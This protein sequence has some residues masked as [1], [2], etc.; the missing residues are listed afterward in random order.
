MQPGQTSRK[1]TLLIVVVSLVVGGV[2]FGGLI[3]WLVRTTGEPVKVIRAHLEAINAGDYVTAYSY[4]SA[5]RQSAMSQEEFRDL[6]EQNSRVMKTHSSSFPSRKITNDVAVIRGTLT[7]QQGEV[8]TIRYTLVREKG[9][10]VIQGFGLGEP[11][12]D[13]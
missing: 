8:V 4:F 9:R 7:G 13:D 6:V 2:P 12:E 1:K 5:T 11:V 10:W 3:W